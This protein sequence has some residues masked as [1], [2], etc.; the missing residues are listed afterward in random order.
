MREFSL[1]SSFQVSLAPAYDYPTAPECDLTVATTCDLHRTLAVTF[2]FEP[3]P[4]LCG[5]F[6]PRFL[7]MARHHGDFFIRRR[8][9]GTASAVG[10]KLSWCPD[11]RA[12]RVSS[13]L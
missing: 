7:S 8:T 12:D 13:K 2:S 5:E 11:P 6:S 1:L 9:T 3:D 10:P 4:D